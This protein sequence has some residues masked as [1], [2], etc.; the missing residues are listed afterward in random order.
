MTVY[1]QTDTNPHDTEHGHNTLRRRWSD[2]VNKIRAVSLWHAETSTR[3]GLAF[4]RFDNKFVLILIILSV[5]T[6][7]SMSWYLRDW[8]YQVWDQ[9]QDVFTLGD[10]TPLF[11]T[12]D[13]PYFL[14]LAQDIKRDGVVGDFSESR[15]SRINTQE[16][17]NA[18]DP[19]LR[20]TPLLS[21]LISALAEDS[22]VKAILEA[23]HTLIPITA[24]LTALM[25]IIGLGTTGYW[26]E[27]CLA[28][29]GGSLCSAY[30]VRSGAGRIDTDQLNLGFFYLILGI[31][32]LSA[33]TKRLPY[34]LVLAAL[35]GFVTWI[36]D[37]WYPKDEFT[38]IF[39]IGLIW[40]NFALHLNIRRTALMAAL[41]FGLSGMW[42]S[43]VSLSS[44]YISD[45]ISFEGLIFP[46]TFD[47]I[48]EL[49]IVPVPEILS[50][51]TGSVAL[52]IFCIIGLGLWGLRHP[53]MAIVFAPAAGFAL[54]NF[55][56]GNRTI[57]YAAPIFWFGGA[58]LVLAISRAIS[59][60]GW[61]QNRFGDFS[62][63]IGL[64]PAMAGGF[65]LIWSV[66]PTTYIQSP[67]FPRPII[68]GF[69]ALQQTPQ[70]RKSVVATWW[71]YGYS[72]VLFNRQHVLHD[73][74]RQT[75]PATYFM[76]RFLL[77]GSQAYSA[78]HIRKL[79]DL[80][81]ADYIALLRGDTQP[82]DYVPADRDVYLVLTRQMAGWMGSIS[83]IGNWD[84]QTGAPFDIPGLPAGQPFI[85]EPLQCRPTDKASVFSCQNKRLD[86]QTGQLGDQLILDGMVM[87]N[88]GVQVGGQK[89]NPSNSAYVLHA[90]TA[91]GMQRN[92]LLHKQLFGSV[93][94]Q[95]FYLR[96]FDPDLFSLVYDG[97]PDIRIYRINRPVP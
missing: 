32:V 65:F 35:A 72:S 11:T 39:F 85:Y 31:I 87:S 88:K 49:N 38:W 46:N 50:R 22:S 69:S 57:F 5:I 14:G 94:H 18:A 62:Q 63:I 74:G 79:A 10:G 20:Q 97:Y 42:A 40:L 3:L 91:P 67:T 73:G 34:A 90:E 28:A 36:F 68:E 66:S 77:S 2:Y 44:N 25:I 71:D 56:F 24:G 96:R 45:I 76:A 95:L 29:A 37:W 51:I 59:D 7:S 92:M 83:M 48:T 12:T 60:S 47:T 4:P 89:F 27:A 70:A 9:N 52:G 82:S 53:G 33:R 1:R 21:V 55:V 17:N 78:E 6:A 8:Q 86:L 43:S 26:L 61:A 81:Y 54:L 64:A 84:I 15:K 30:L 93:F 58:Y 19:S 75:T 41:F 16:D 13:A 80:G 23:G